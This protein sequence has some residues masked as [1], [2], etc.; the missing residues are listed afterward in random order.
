MLGDLASIYP[1]NLAI[2]FDRA[3]DISVPSLNVLMRLLDQSVRP[4]IV[5]AA[6]PGISQ[7]LPRHQDPTFIPGDHYDIIHVGL[8]PYDDLWQTFV[9]GATRNYLAAN[10]II[11][12]D[13][14]DLR[15]T[16][17]MSRD[18]IRQAVSFAQIAISTISSQLED[19]EI[20]NL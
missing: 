18:S 1:Y 6:R 4:L 20:A 12:S 17:R 11:V 7:L 13:D 8:N 3:E 5:I 19:H 15:W 10:E 2:F 14:I 9:K 16:C